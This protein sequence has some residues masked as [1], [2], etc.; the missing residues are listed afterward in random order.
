VT[1]LPTILLEHALHCG[2]DTH[3]IAD[4]LQGTEAGAF[5]LWPRAHSVVITQ[6]QD[7]PQKRLL[8]IFL[9]AGIMDELQD[10]LPDVLA[11]G[12]AQGCAG[13]YLNGRLGWM[14]SFL[15]DQGWTV[16]SVTMVKNLTNE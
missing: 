12:R 15:R 16:Q 9:A 13:A 5:Q 8:C 4:V 6:L 10:V 3:T 2:G 14:R 7:F 11:F 1:Q